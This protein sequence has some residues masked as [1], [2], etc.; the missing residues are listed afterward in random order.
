MDTKDMDIIDL[1]REI[2]RKLQQDENYIKF[3]LAKQ[4]TDED[5]VLQDMIGEF[6]LKRMAINNE[7]SKENRSEEK[8]QQLNQELRSVYA[9]IMT[10][11]NMINYNDSKEAVD[12]ILAR[13]SAIIQKSSEGEDPETADYTPSCSGS[14]ATCGGCH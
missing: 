8:L 4:A 2:G 6:N 13:V 11:E 3:Q 1:A 7:A 5:A 9:K 12:T 14:C 10:N